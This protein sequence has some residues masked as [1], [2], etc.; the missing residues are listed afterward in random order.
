MKKLFAAIIIFFILTY[1]ASAE[2]RFPKPEFSGGYK[3]P[4]TT[5]TDSISDYSYLKIA[6]LIGILILSGLAVYK[7]RSR[8]LILFISL[9]NLAVFGFIM[10]GCVCPAG[11]V[12]NI[13]SYFFGDSENFTVITGLLFFIPL[14]TAMFFGRLFCISGCPLGAIQEL[15]HFKTLRVPFATDKILRFIPY[16]ILC[17]TI[18]MA[19]SGAGYLVCSTDPF[20]GIFRK[21]SFA[22]IGILSVIILVISTFISRPYC[23]YFC[24][25]SVLLRFLSFLSNKSIPIYSGDCVECR[26]CENACP[27]NAII[28]GHADVKDNTQKKAVNK[29]GFL[30]ITLPFFMLLGGFLFLKTSGYFLDFHKDIKLYN[31]LL[32]IEK[33][34]TEYEV[35]AFLSSGGS[36]EDL[37]KMYTKKVYFI[38]TGFAF[39]GMAI[40]LFI[41]LDLRLLLRKRKNK[42]PVIDMS[43]C[44]NCLRCLKSCPVN[45]KNRN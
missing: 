11:S 22:N 26:L 6:V 41:V 36:F 2:L 29:I 42:N 14:I 44:Y 45:K 4:A 12:Q 27:N 35:Q 43:L 10:V 25:Y 32:N 15:I 18:V 28:P 5:L 34:K 23:R 37:K 24:H 39:S 38:K 40:V 13:A 33:N 17:L 8:K 3:V 16:L 20:I 31:M 21:A 19:G 7:M 9:I 1:T 30:I